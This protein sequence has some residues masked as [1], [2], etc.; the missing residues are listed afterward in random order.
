MESFSRC[1]LPICVE[2]MSQEYVLKNKADNSKASIKSSGTKKFTTVSSTNFSHEM[3]D[4]FLVI[5][6]E[7]YR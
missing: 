7:Y 4:C 3:I 5:Y 1:L 2:A 6:G